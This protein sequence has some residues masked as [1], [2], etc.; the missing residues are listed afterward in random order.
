MAQ[1]A[2]GT[3]VQQSMQETSEWVE[4]IA[5]RL[6]IDPEEAIG[7]LRECLQ[8][9]RDSITVD[10]ATD[11]GARLPI[12]VRGLYYHQW[13]PSRVPSGHSRR[14]ALDELGAA[15]PFSTAG[16]DPEDSLN[17]VASLLAARI[18]WGEIAD[19]IS[20][21]PGWLGAILKPDDQ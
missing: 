20:Q 12:V 9:I 2:V 16:I 1:H 15:A 17:A 18:S 21:A 3:T 4:A 5:D 14:Q 7:V 10:E 19:V 6:D 13:Q 11:L 8:V